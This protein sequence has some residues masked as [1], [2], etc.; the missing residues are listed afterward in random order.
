MNTNA[1]ADAVGKHVDELAKPS[2]QPEELY[3]VV[4]TKESLEWEVVLA[5]MG[6]AGHAAIATAYP[7]LAYALDYAQLEQAHQGA[8][9]EKVF[10]AR[11][12]W[13]KRPVHF[14]FVV[15]Q[16]NRPVARIIVK[17]VSLTAAVRRAAKAFPGCHFQP[18]GLL[19]G[20]E[21][22]IGFMGYM[23]Q[24][25]NPFLAVRDLREGGG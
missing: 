24:M 1:L 2:F 14:D 21:A 23:S 5:P 9:N 22:A 15:I 3:F 7:D 17:A 16:D 19:E 25:D 6:E 12:F 10:Q 8:T 4:P 18:L 11:P 20:Y 13:F